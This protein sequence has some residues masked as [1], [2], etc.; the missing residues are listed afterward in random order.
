VLVLVDLYKMFLFRIYRELYHRFTTF[1]SLQSTLA[2]NC[3]LWSNIWSVYWFM[4]TDVSDGTLYLEDI[5]RTVFLNSLE[6]GRKTLLSNVGSFNIH[7]YVL[8]QYIRRVQPTRWNISQLIYFC[9]TLYMFQTVFPSIIRSTKLHI[10]RQVFVRPLLLLAASL[11]RLAAGSSIGLINA[12]RCMCSFVLLM[13]SGNPS[14][15]CR[16][17]YRNK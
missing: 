8:R 13:M 12:W 3:V 15:T 17:S 4:T 11:A 5:H 14:E 2:V 7:S 1:R 9:K 6:D 16:A 10:Q